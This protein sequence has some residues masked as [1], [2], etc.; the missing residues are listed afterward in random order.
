[1]LEHW[2]FFC[3]LTVKSLSLLSYFLLLFVIATI[4][5]FIHSFMYILTTGVIEKMFVEQ[6]IMANSVADP[7]QVSDA[8]TM[9]EYLKSTAAAATTTTTTCTDEEQYP[10]LAHKLEPAWTQPKKEGDMVPNVKFRTRT[11]VQANKDDFDWLDVTTRDLMEDK[12]VVVFALPGAFTPTCSASHLPGYETAYDEIKS[13]GIDEVYCLS[14]ND[15]H[16]MR[17]WGL[18]QGLVEKNNKTVGNFEKVKLIPD[19][20]ASFTRSMGMSIVW[21]S[22]RGFG[23]RSWRYSMV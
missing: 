22:E 6:P 14:V 11:R 17:Q 1:V 19:G 10:E 5:S 18:Q 13:L 9:L 2:I 7:F 23:E 15:A 16:V 8:Q 12:R 4:H 20:T 21:S 3:V